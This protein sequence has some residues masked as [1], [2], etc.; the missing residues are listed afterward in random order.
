VN[1]RLL[2]FGGAGF[3]G[4]NLS[5]L[6]L[7]DG[8]EVH[9]ADAAVR[10][11]LPGARWHRIDIT[12][13]PTVAA[14]VGSVEPAAVVDLAAVA[15][16]DRAERERDLARA[17]NADAARAV[18]AASAAAG[19]SFVYFSSDAVFAGTAYRYVEEDAPDPVNWYGQTKADGERLVRE[20]H[21]RAAVVRI[22]LVLGFPVT[23]GNS[24]IASLEKKLAAGAAVPCPV[25]E[26]RTPIDVLTLSAA[27]LELCRTGF[28]G[29]LHLGSTDSVDRFT[30]TRRAAVLMGFDASL[31][32]AQ[33]P[34]MVQQPEPVGSPAGAAQ[35]ARAARHRRG[36]ISVEKARRLLSTPMRDWETSLRRAVEGRPGNGR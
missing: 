27:V 20:V 31:V 35:H 29:T 34:G 6:A 17:V 8:W 19:A 3:V 14:L 24:F 32:T 28:A 13:G 33:Q 7:R 5:A 30:L 10:D 21:P 18:A 15:D 36:V 25:H 4:G 11:A 1:R 26:I 12:D 16:I 2:V 9:V 22:S 23:S